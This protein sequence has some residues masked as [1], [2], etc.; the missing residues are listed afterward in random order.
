LTQKFKK[1]FLEF[2]EKLYFRGFFR[3]WQEIKTQEKEDGTIESKYK[4]SLQQL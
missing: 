1:N 2:F 4:P 3:N